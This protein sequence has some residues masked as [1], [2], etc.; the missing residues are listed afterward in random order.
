M[1]TPRHHSY[2]CLSSEIPRR[3][4]PRRTRHIRL[5]DRS[6]YPQDL[7]PAFE[8]VRTRPSGLLGGRRGAPEEAGR[9]VVALRFFP[10]RVRQ[11]RARIHPAVMTDAFFEQIYVHCE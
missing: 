10:S 5:P 9:F 8:K 11:A 4:S 3:P 6:R 7:P 2:V 1:R